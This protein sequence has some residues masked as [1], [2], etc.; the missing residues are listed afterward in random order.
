MAS[1]DER[2]N[3]KDNLKFTILQKITGYYCTTVTLVYRRH[4]HVARLLGL[5]RDY[6][7]GASLD[8]FGFSLADCLSASWTSA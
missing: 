1:A 5:W 7:D 6:E 2:V 8:C 3:H 4:S